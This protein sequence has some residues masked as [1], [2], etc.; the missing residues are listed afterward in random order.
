MPSPRR[1]SPLLLPRTVRLRL[2]LLYGALFA[3]SGACLFTVAY[4][5][6]VSGSPSQ[7]VA[8]QPRTEGPGATA[9]GHGLPGHPAQQLQTGNLPAVFHWTGLDHVLA[10]SGIALAIMTAISLIVGWFAAGRMLRP[11]RAMTTT[12]RRI[13]ERNLHQRLAVPG[14]R[15]ELKD[16]GDTI[17]SLLDRLETVVAAQRQF[18][19]NASHELRTPLTLQRTLL[20]SILT[21]PSPRPAAWRSA[22]ERTLAATQKQAQLIEALLTLARSQQGPGHREPIDLAP[23]MAGVIRALEPQATACSV[24]VKTELESSY[25]SGDSGLIERLASNLLDNAIRHNVPHGWVQ[26]LIHEQ[27]TETTLRVTNTGP[28]IPAGQVSRL[29]QPFQRLGSQRAGR[30][31]GVGLGLSIV[32]AIASTHTAALSVCPGPQGGLDIKITFPG[33]LTPPATL[34]T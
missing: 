29:L 3:V 14:P 1:L 32:A 4:L 31:D 8:V 24:T 9:P 34:A 21:H 33:S 20:E 19:A 23:L 10:I 28:V 30:H 15:D 2:T 18:A 17:D 22:C 5:L 25:I 26:V 13:S 6:I 7:F 12:A 27:A 11:L 16:L